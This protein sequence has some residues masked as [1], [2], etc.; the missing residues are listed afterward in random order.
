MP[1]GKSIDN[2][3]R[4]FACERKHI[5]E[6]IEIEYYNKKRL[7]QWQFNADWSFHASIWLY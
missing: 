7:H 4:K 2:L 1:T 5:K 6:Q 3:P